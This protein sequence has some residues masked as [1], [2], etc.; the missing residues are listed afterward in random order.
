MFDAV[1]E[2]N[3]VYAMEYF[4]LGSL[5]APARPL[6]R[7]TVLAALEHAAR[8]AHALHEAG[9]A[10]SDIKPANVLVADGSTADG[11]L[12]DLGLARFLGPGSP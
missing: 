11:A 1:L 3:F 10:H 8:A 7:P 4:P 12:S 5:A 2:D 6:P 9:M